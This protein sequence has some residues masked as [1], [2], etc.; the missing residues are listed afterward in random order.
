MDKINRRDMLSLLGVALAGAAFMA[1]P[2]SLFAAEAQKRPFALAQ[3]PFS[4][5]PKNLDQKDIGT[6][7][8][9]GYDY[10]GYGCSFGVFYGIIGLMG[11][12]YGKPYSDFPFTM[13]EVG[14][15]GISNQG[16][17]CGALLG[18][19]SALSLFWG[20]KERDPMTEQLFRWY[21]TQT[22]PIYK[23]EGKSI[24][25]EGDLPGT[26]S[27]SVLCHISV[28][29][30]TYASGFSEKSEQRSER[31][32]RITADVALKTWEIIQAKMDGTSVNWFEKSASRKLCGECHDT[33][34][35]SPILKGKM[36]CSPCHS[37]AVGTQNKFKDHPSPN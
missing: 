24:Y 29:K 22:L 28:G 12:I 31:C 34:K 25:F 9:K 14:K 11:E 6:T 35:E 21:E 32:A 4:W 3:L 23:P 5:I 36:E 13:M 19:A 8:Y 37:G 27:D 26:Q 7:A 15:G 17:I 1:G 10:K 18:G 2:G 16:T 30:W 33:G 20:R